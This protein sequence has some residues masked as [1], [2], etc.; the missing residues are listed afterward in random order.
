MKNEIL[1]KIFKKNYELIIPPEKHKYKDIQFV[2]GQWWFPV[3]G[4][5]T[6][7]HLLTDLEY[8]L[9]KMT[10]HRKEPASSASRPQLSPNSMWLVVVECRYEVVRVCV[11]GKGFYIPGQEPCW[12]F[13]HAPEW[14]KE[15]IPPAIDGAEPAK[16]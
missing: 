16:I 13:D 8:V 10:V 6:M 12:G 2:D 5:D 7:D 14:I 1:K 11:S 9:D 4:C 15:I 3:W